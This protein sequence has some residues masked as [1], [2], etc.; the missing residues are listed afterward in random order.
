MGLKGK[1]V[2]EPT[3]ASCPQRTDRDVEY[4]LRTS[5]IVLALLLT[6]SMSVAGAEPPKIGDPAPEIHGKPWINSQSLT[7]TDLRGKVALVEFWT[8]G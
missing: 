7:L 6:W 3:A 5:G 1:P 4:V 8:Y 2:A